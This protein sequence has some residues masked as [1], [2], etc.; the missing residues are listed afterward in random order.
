M[1]KGTLTSN[2]LEPCW[3]PKW[4][5]ND[6]NKEEVHSSVGEIRFIKVLQ[7]NEDTS[8]DTVELT[9]QDGEND[10]E[11]MSIVSSC[12]DLLERVMVGC[13]AWVI[14]MIKKKNEEIEDGKTLND[15]YI[16]PSLKQS[17]RKWAT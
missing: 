2:F 7:N 17:G 5:K 4:Y 12:L 6:R 16:L 1:W 11:N 3:S 15:K 9:D 13:M 10:D 8:K 14:I